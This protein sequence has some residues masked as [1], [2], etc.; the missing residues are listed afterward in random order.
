VGKLQNNLGSSEDLWGSSK[1]IWVVQR[2]CGKMQN[3]LGSAEDL[4]GSC[5]IIWVVQSICVEAAK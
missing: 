5:K 1:I 3:N 2:I 4:W